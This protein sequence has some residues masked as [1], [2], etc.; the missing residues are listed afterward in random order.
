MKFLNLCLKKT[1]KR[2]GYN[3]QKN[4]RI[5]IRIELFLQM[6]VHFNYIHQ[7]KVW[8]F[9][10]RK[11]VFRSVKYLPKVH[12]WECFSASGFDKLFCF[13]RNL[14]AEFMCTI[15]E[16]GLLTSTSKLFGESN[17]D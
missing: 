3:G 13:Q 10:S 14:N 7:K 6:R 9:P 16:Q 5:L 1:I 12:V 8:Q 17:I 2:K 15:Y 11:K 4:I